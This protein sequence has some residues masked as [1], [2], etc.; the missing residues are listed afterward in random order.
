MPSSDFSHNY[1]L[2]GEVLGEDQ[3]P[4]RTMRFRR[5]FARELCEICRDEG[6]GLFMGLELGFRRVQ[7]EVELQKFLCG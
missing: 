3:G 2:K 1:K 6:D 5:G 4:Q 7:E